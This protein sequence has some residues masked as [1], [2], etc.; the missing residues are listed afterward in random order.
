MAQN[1]S[2]Y[3]LYEDN[4]L[5]VDASH[6]LKQAIFGL[7]QVSTLPVVL[8]G[9]TT[10]ATHPFFLQDAAA[11][12]ITNGVQIGD[13]VYNSTDLSVGVVKSVDSEIKLTTTAMVAG[14][15]GL[16]NTGDGYSVR[17]VPEQVILLTANDGA[18]GKG[19]Y[20]RNV[21]NTAWEEVH[22]GG[23]PTPI[24]INQLDSDIQNPTYSEILH[25]ETS[26]KEVVVFPNVVASGW[27]Q[28]ILPPGY[29]VTKDL[30]F[31]V[32][33]ENEEAGGAY[34]FGMDYWVLAHNGNT[35]PVS[36]TGTLAVGASAVAP[37]LQRSV[38]ISGLT[39]PAS[40]LNAI[41][42]EIIFKFS[43]FGDDPSDTNMGKLYISEIMFFQD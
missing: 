7:L 18:N 35:A 5:D 23:S 37:N 1:T 28:F 38:V 32:V 4:V 20:K 15:D 9:T 26:N 42:D 11:T 41:G 22:V 3:F 40:S 34:R 6:Q 36:P 12:F 27:S 14:G 19:L 17:G 10:G 24:T 39:I 16:W 31:R 8:T 29:D 25:P 43:R 33:L 13:V 21:G 2:T 30:K